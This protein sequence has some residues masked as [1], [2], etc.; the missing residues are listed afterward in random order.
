MKN[1]RNLIILAG[2]MIFS[3]IYF[4]RW[5][6]LTQYSKP[7][8]DLL[9]KI[10]TA[11]ADQ[12]KFK[13]TIAIQTQ[14]IKNLSSQNYPYR[15][16]PWP[17]DF[18]ENRYQTWLLEVGQFCHFE[19]FSVDKQ[20]RRATQTYCILPYQLNARTSFDQLSRFLYEFYWSPYL[21]KITQMNITP[22]ENTDLVNVSMRIEAIVLLS[23]VPANAP[24]PLTNQFPVGHWSRLSSGLLETYTEPID[25]RNL[26]QFVRGGVDASDFTRLTAINYIGN[27][28]EIWLSNQTNDTTIRA[29][30]GDQIRV[31][32]FI[33]KIVEV[34]EQDVVFETP[35]SSSR[36]SMRWLVTL[37]ES[38]NQATA[39]PPEN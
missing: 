21:H 34:L 15:S 17:V 12:Q 39:L 37:G 26:M 19:N 23:K 30:V 27:E 8:N 36:V 4:G 38:L 16:L 24:Y 5:A 3:S 25:A 32:S 28:P 14:T 2:I 6:Y 18:A 13:S 20:G 31:G 33:G 29:K 10:E 35:G 22:V 9:A 1:W 7:R 11:K